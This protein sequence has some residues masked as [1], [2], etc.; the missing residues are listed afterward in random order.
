MLLYSK[1]HRVF[2]EI[3]PLDRPMGNHVTNSKPKSIIHDIKVLTGS[4]PLYHSDKNETLW[5]QIYITS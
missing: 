4:V 2:Q 1:K 3:R 5:S